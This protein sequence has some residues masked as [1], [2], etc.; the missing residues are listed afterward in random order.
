[1]CAHGVRLRPSH[2]R[3]RIATLDIGAAERA[4]GVIA[5]VTGGEVKPLGPMPVNRLIPDMR[6]PPHPI[7]ADRLVHAAGTPVAAVLALDVYTARDAA[8]LIRVEYEPLP[9]LPTPEAAVADGAPV[10]FPDIDRNR[11]FTPPPP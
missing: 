7:I 4:R 6:V 11:S 8:E 3:A 2:A 1:D 9:A 10:L 5:V